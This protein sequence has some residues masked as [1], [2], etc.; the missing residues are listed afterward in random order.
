V[1]SVW[2]S[3]EGEIDHDL[4]LFESDTQPSEILSV[5]ER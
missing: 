1:R 5:S 4:L 3:P 2:V